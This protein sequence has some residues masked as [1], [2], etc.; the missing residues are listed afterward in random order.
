MNG[1]EQQ[2][3][4]RFG[5]LVV[6]AVRAPAEEGD[7]AAPDVLLE[8]IPERGLDSAGSRRRTLSRCHIVWLDL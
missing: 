8:S 4:E 1:E 6:P 3:A 2:Q 5:I 7:D